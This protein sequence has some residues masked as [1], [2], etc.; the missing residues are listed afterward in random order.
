MD[1][2]TIDKN[3]PRAEMDGL[4]WLYSQDSAL[5]LPCLMTQVM[6]E[7]HIAEAMNELAE[8]LTDK[9]ADQFKRLHHRK[10]KRKQVEVKEIDIA[11]D[12]VGSMEGSE[13]DP[14]LSTTILSQ[15]V[16]GG[17]LTQLQVQLAKTGAGVYCVLAATAS[18]VLCSHNFDA[19]TTVATA[20]CSCTAAAMFVA[21][22]LHE[23]EVYCGEP[24][25]GPGEDGDTFAL[26][27]LSGIPQPWNLGH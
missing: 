18:L 12:G 20:C 1:V 21:C 2:A 4:R 15:V 23:T 11:H 6:T 17:K 19:A 24:Q 14:E 5:V 27:M 7:G 9:E 8:G 3:R 16:R 25:G 10:R 22:R 13:L 26:R